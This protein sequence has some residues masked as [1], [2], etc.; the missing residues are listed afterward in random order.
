M[1]APSITAFAWATVVSSSPT[2]SGR[3]TRCEAKNGARKQPIRKTIASSSGKLSRPAAC[4]S[5]SEHI[6]G[7]RARSQS[8]IVRRAPSRA[9][10]VPLGMPSSAIGAIWTARTIP[11]FA[12]EPVVTSTNH[13]SARNVIREPSE[14]TTS[15]A[16]R[17]ASDRFRRICTRENIVRPYVFVK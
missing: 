17:A 7:T 5:G 10:S 4:R 9:T 3:I 8:C 13:G 16:I 12:A 6:S 11:I 2:S 15:A 1:V 14:L